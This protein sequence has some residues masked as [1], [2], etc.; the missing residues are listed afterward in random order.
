MFV[1]AD[2]HIGP[3]VP[4][5]MNR[6]MGAKLMVHTGTVYGGAVCGPMWASAPTGC[7]VRVDAPGRL[8]LAR[9][10]NSPSVGIG[11]YGVHTV[12]RTPHAM[13]YR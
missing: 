5:A 2:A 8:L 7:G 6:R 1:G 9:W 3:A 11:P 4:A 13:G 12:I 10:A